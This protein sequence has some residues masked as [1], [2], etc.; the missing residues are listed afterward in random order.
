MP[1]GKFLLALYL[2]VTTPISA[3]FFA[4]T[5]KCSFHS[6]SVKKIEYVRNFQIRFCFL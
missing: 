4:I 5:G 6:L 1:L 2:A 3:Y